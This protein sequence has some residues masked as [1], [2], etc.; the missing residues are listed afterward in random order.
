[1]LRMSVE[2]KVGC[3]VLMGIL[4]LG[5][6]SL[7]LGDLPFV[8]QSGYDLHVSFDSAAGLSKKA[9]V[10]IAGVNVGKVQNILLKNGKALVILKINH[11][12]KISKSV[13]AI[14]RTSGMM[15]DKYVELVYQDLSPPFL[16][17]GEMVINTDTPTDVDTLLSI[18]ADVARDIKILSNSFTGAIKGEEGESPIRSIVNSVRDMTDTLNRNIQENNENISKIIVNFADFSDKLKEIGETNHESIYHVIQNLKRTSDKFEDLIIRIN[19]ITA[20]INRGKGTLGKL[21]NDD[22]AIHHLTGALE[23]IDEIAE[24]INRGK[25]SVGKLINDDKTVENI[26]N[27]LVSINDYVNKKDKYLTHLNYS[28]EYLFKQQETKSYITLKIQPRE[29]KYYLIQLVDDSE[30]KET[31]KDITRTA[32]SVTTTEHIVKTEKDTLKISAQIAKRYDN[33]GIR[34]GLFESTGGL[35]L[36]YYMLDDR[37]SFSFE[38]FDFDPDARAHLKFKACYTPIKHLYISSGFDDFISDEGNTSFFFGAGISF[39]D[40]DIKSFLSSIPLPTN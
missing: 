8:K 18:L 30:G 7:K 38:A 35:G 33:I 32:D 28:G 2:A 23:S 5:Y 4:L 36:D 21:I 29:D 31:I 34:G 26:N 15:G 20:K 12:I 39:F 3:F 11:G 9:T 10:T 19:D 1:M 16:Q 24:K 14:I 27:S 25:G 22:E 17:H 40:Q 6:M 37:L 13:K